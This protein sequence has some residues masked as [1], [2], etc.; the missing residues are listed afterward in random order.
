VGLQAAKVEFWRIFGKST[1]WNQG[2]INLTEGETNTCGWDVVIAD[3]L[4]FMGSAMIR[5]LPPF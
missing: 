2:S 3:M 1:S 4:N 5:E